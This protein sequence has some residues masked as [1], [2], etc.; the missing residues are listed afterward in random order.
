MINFCAN[1]KFLKN[2]TKYC[3]YTGELLN[4]DNPPTIEHIEVDKNTRHHHSKRV[5]EVLVVGKNANEKMRGGKPFD[6]F[7]REHPEVV[8]NIVGQVDGWR[9]ENLKQSGEDVAAETIKTLNKAAKG[10]ARF[11]GNKINLEV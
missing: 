4:Q 3:A 8:S 7:L 11:G 10:V 5:G 1:G 6:R 9:Y 2:H